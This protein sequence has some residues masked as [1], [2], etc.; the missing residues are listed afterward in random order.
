MAH[1]TARQEV[2]ALLLALKL[3]IDER[4][5]QRAAARALWIA[6]AGAPLATHD[7]LAAE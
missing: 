2:E 5:R 3:P 4:G 7:I 1:L 6:S